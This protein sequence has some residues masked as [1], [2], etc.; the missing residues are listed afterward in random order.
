MSFFPGHCENLLVILLHAVDMCVL[1]VERHSG[2]YKQQTNN[3]Q[4]HAGGGCLCF[5]LHCVSSSI[6]GNVCRFTFQFITTTFCFV[7]IDIDKYN[8][9]MN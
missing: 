7:N 2:Q 5:Q 6:G 1:L 8:R 9:A 4:L 3:N